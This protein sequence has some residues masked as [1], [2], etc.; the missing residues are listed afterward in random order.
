MEDHLETHD[1][2]KTPLSVHWCYQGRTLDYRKRTEVIKGG[3]RIS[4]ATPF[5][6]KTVEAELSPPALGLVGVVFVPST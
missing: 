6:E 5:K 4:K 2:K 3:R 1:I